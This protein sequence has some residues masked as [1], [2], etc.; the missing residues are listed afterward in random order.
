[1]PPRRN[2]ASASEY[3]KTN[4]LNTDEKT[5]ISKDRCEFVFIDE[6]DKHIK[7]FEGM[8]ASDWIYDKADYSLC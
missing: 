1:M 6:C 4:L 3:V 5:L 7:A 8:R 2:I